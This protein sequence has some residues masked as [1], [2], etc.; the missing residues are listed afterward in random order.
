MTAPATSA[1]PVIRPD[2]LLA[3]SERIAL[4][5]ATEKA[6]HDGC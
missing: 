3:R 5:R 2:R 6:A 1:G 4:I